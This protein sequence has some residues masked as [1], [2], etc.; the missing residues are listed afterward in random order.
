ML[1]KYA[2]VNTEYQSRMKNLEE[3]NERLKRQ[4]GG[5]TGSLFN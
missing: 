5:G 2:A 1:E 3:E 4:I